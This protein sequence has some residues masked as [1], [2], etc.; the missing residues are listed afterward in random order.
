MTREKKELRIVE[1]RS[2]NIKKL[3]VVNITPDGNMVYITGE[4]G[5]GKS[6]V[7]DSI[8]MA[9]SGRN[10]IPDKPI[11]DGEEKGEITVDLGEY[12]VT[13]TFKEHSKTLKVSSKD[14]ATYSSPQ[15]MLN[16][17]VGKL[18]FDPTHFLTLPEK[19]QRKILLD[20]IGVDVIPINETRTAKY[21]ERTIL[22]R[23]IK[24]LVGRLGGRAVKEKYGKEEYSAKDILDEIQ[25]END[26]RNKV[27]DLIREINNGVSHQNTCKGNIS[28]KEKEIENLKE[29][30]SG[31]EDV[32]I[33]IDA[34]LIDHAKEK[35]AIELGNIDELKEKLG[36]VEEVNAA[37]RSNNEAR[38]IQTELNTYEESKKFLT[39][40]I[41][42][43]DQQKEDMIANAK[44]PIKGL[45]FSDDAVV[46]E[47]IP[48]K[49]VNSAD[50]FKICLAM[51]MA[52]N[53][54]LKVIL[55][56]NGSLLDKKNLKY[57]A[58]LAEK[59]NYQIWIERVD[60]SGEM[61]IVIEDGEVKSE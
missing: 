41:E 27:Q 3:K 44:M 24:D 29:E 53:P 40:E 4:N 9:L 52:L 10:S 42:K 21:E 25:K 54:Q 51:G 35:E 61:G 60:E 12:I 6:S 13:R 31:L 15:D 17:I 55:F 46:F 49:Q 20:L 47:G 34:E 43:I 48:L 56:K 18:S 58:K 1:L 50:Q 26:K 23:S 28:N 8:E 45:S 57:V 37:I 59:N 7:L 19:E 11:R 14:G 22:G 33:S 2:E 5:A 38:K 16:N 39:I 36:K 32:I 30:I